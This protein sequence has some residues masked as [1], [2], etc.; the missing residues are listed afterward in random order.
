MAMCYRVPIASVST[1]LRQMEYYRP[2]YLVDADALLPSDS[3]IGIPNVQSINAN[4]TTRGR[5]LETTQAE[6][7]GLLTE[8]TLATSE[9]GI[10]NVAGSVDG[11]NTIRTVALLVVSAGVILGVV[12]HGLS[13]VTVTFVDDGSSGRL[14]GVGGVGIDGLRNGGC[15]I[16]IGGFGLALTS[17]EQRGVASVECPCRE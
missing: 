6:S 13:E 3:V 10:E 2:T 12:L 4:W 9:L 15:N 5:I 17:T 11:G 14:V 8:G 1:Y 16:G 7:V